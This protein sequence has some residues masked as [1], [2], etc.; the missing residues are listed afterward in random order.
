ME[1]KTLKENSIL[2]VANMGAGG[3]RGSEIKMVGVF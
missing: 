1:N 3:W 2:F